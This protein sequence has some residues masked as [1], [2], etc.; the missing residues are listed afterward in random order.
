MPCL[1]LTGNVE[2]RLKKLDMMF[3]TGK[4]LIGERTDAERHSNVGRSVKEAVEW[5]NEGRKR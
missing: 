5:K 1:T 4:T 3:D 2:I